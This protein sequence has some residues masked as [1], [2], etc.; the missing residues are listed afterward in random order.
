MITLIAGV[1]VIFVML[2]TTHLTTIVMLVI[3]KVHVALASLFFSIFVAIEGVY[4]SALMN[5]VAEGGWVPF[6]IA[7]FLLVPTLAWTY[8]RKLKAEY[9]ARHAVGEAELGALVAR[10]ARAPGVCVFCADLVNGFPPIV[11]RYAEHTACLRELTVFVTVRDVPVRSVLPEE[12]FLVERQ[13]TAGVYR[14]VVQYGYTDKHD[15]VGDEFVG[16]AIAALKEAAG[17]AEEAELMGSALREGYVFVFGRT[18]L[19]MGQEHN[20]WKRFV[21]NILYRFL[22]KNFRSSISALKIDH[23]KTLQVGM[24]YEI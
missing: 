21:V 8:G 6:A 19:Q 14:C 1:A 12:R 9:E 13:H 3:W 24:Q 23:A 22:Q 7:A 16:S 20:L 5:K 10:I 18:I 11:R 2:I 17:C 4:M 15:L